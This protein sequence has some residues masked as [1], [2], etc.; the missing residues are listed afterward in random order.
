MNLFLIAVCG[1][2]A[3][4]LGL[5]WCYM[6]ALVL[7]IFSLYISDM[8][9]EYVFVVNPSAHQTLRK[10]FLPGLS[11]AAVL[12]LALLYLFGAQGAWLCKACYHMVTNR[13][14][15]FWL[16]RK[17]DVKVRTLIF[18]DEVEQKVVEM[19]KGGSKDAGGLK[20]LFRRTPAVEDVDARFD[21]T[22]SATPFASGGMRQAFLALAA[23]KDES[24]GPVMPKWLFTSHLA[25]KKYKGASSVSR[26]QL[27]GVLLNDIR[28]QF[29]ARRYASQ[30]ND[31]RPPKEVSF[32]PAIVVEVVST[33][34][35]LWIEPLLDGDLYEKY[36]NNAGYVDSSHATPEAFS[37][38]TYD[39]SNGEIL[40]V[41]LQG[42]GMTFTDPQ[43]HTSLGWM[44]TF[45]FMVPSDAR[46]EYGVGNNKAHGMSDW[47]NSHECN[48]V[49]KALKLRPF[50]RPNGSGCSR[51]PLG[52]KKKPPGGP[53]QT[54]LELHGKKFAATKCALGL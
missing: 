32:T 29:V 22:Y 37:H 8:A 20:G 42:V 27:H 21:I 17:E 53:V 44:K 52:G 13:W 46:K 50:D 47:K 12:E 18:Y 2:I 5:L 40:I 26:E 19:P 16:I 45:L 3:L 43:I 15:L 14:I 25:V 4:L 49:C 36:N 10:P 41:D 48:E 31:C 7:L 34:E 39:H 33:N 1:L 28:M 23:T 54:I 6:G 35:L 30:F 51:T 9:L 38:F 11:V 24:K